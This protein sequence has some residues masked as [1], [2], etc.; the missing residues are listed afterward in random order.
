MT[1]LKNIVLLKVPF[2]SQKG[3]KSSFGK[4][5]KGLTQDW[6][7][8]WLSDNESKPSLPIQQNKTHF[9]YFPFRRSVPVV[10]PLVFCTHRF[11]GPVY[12][13]FPRFLC[14]HQIFVIFLIRWMWSACSQ[15]NHVD[16]N[17]LQ[18]P[19]T[20]TCEVN[21]IEIWLGL[22]YSYKGIL[23]L[24]GLFLAWETRNVKIPA[25]NDSHHIGNF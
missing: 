15:N 3:L 2:S 9:L 1:D 7:R 11:S 13:L 25:L 23:L 5:A 8:F 17:I 10:S 14:L 4:N 21:R 20:Y 24:F 6:N 16:D 19:Y 12:S 22:L 18:L